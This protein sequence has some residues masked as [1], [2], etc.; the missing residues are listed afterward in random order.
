MTESMRR[1]IRDALLAHAFGEREEALEA[2]RR[3]LGD[4]LYKHLYPAALQ[5]KMK[6][7]PNGFLP[8]SEAQQVK[9]GGDWMPLE[10]GDSRPVSVDNRRNAVVLDAN[11]PITERFRDLRNRGDRL[12]AEKGEAAAKANAA[13]KNATTINKLLKLW[14]EVAPFVEPYLR[15]AKPAPLPVVQTEVLNKTFDLPVS[16]TSKPRKKVV[17]KGPAEAKF[18]RR[19]FVS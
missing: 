1:S 2:E 8:K 10:W 6:A 12:R 13:L 15:D 18:V 7:L 11:H 3:K 19:G 17:K 5:K 16:A 9:L 14:P 4:D